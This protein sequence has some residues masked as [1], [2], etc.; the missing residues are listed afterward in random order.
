M[1]IKIDKESIVDGMHRNTALLALK[2]ENGVNI[3]YTEDDA[4]RVEPLWIASL[5]ELLQIL[6]PFARMSVSGSGAE[7]LLSLPANW[8]DSRE[9]TLGTLASGYL[10]TALTARWF[11]AVKPDSAMLFR[12]L[13]TNTANSINDILYLKK[14]P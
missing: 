1:T 13:N 12:S 7:F 14:K 4:Q 11:D 6:Q 2:S 5:D 10:V 9:D 8:D 3:A